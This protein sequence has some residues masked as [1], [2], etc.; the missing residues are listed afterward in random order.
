MFFLL[1]LM[2]FKLFFLLRILDIFWVVG[3]SQPFFE[4]MGQVGLL[5]V[6]GVFQSFSLN[7]TL[8]FL[9]FWCFLRIQG[10][11]GIF[12]ASK[13]F[14]LFFL[15]QGRFSHFLGGRVVSVIFYGYG[16]KL[17]FF[18]FQEYFSHSKVLLN[19]IFWSSILIL[20]F[21][22]YHYILVICR[23]ELYFINMKY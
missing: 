8:Y 20:Y 15:L 12:Q 16:G 3:V 23:K 22:S 5:L 19:Y 10:Y 2:V 9:Q 7:N 18:Q 13:V 21:F 14:Q 4:F 11:F 17:A 1:A 6:L